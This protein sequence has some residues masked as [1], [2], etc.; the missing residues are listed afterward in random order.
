MTAILSRAAFDAAATFVR[1]QGRPLDAALLDH[2][3]G[4][5]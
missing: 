1:E 4:K 5:G 3:L 2:R